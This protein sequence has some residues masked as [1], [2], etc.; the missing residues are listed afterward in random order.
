MMFKKTP[1]EFDA[2]RY[3]AAYPDVALSGL[4]PRQHY[5]QF[6]RQLGRSP[7]GLPRGTA[8]P[9]RPET[10]GQV[11]E[12]APSTSPGCTPVKE[13]LL[14]RS[15]P[16][17]ERP[18]G[19]AASDA[20]S[21]PAPARKGLNGD[22]IFTLDDFSADIPA[23]ALGLERVLAP[24]TDYARLLSFEVPA[25]AGGSE[26]GLRDQS[27]FRKGPTRIENAWF[28]APMT[29]RL[30]VAGVAS[31][32]TTNSGWALR[33]YQAKADSPGQLRAT[34]PG[35]CL[36]AMG[37]GFVDL[38]LVDPLMPLILELADSENVTRAMAIWPFPSL[39]PGGLHA[40]ELRALQT[41]SNPIDGFWDLSE[42]LLREA[43]GELGW[44]A[45]SVRQVNYPLGNDV[46]GHISS[47]LEPWLNA[48]FGVSLESSKKIKSGA[49]SLL[50]LP[51]DCIP[52]ISALV[53]RRLNLRSGDRLSG[54]LLVT[55]GEK[56]R[57]RWSVS[58]P[59]NWP[60][61]ASLPALE[62]I[63][64][65]TKGQSV[66][67]AIPVHLAI[68]NRAP[69]P[70]RLVASMSP[71]TDVAVEPMTIVIDASDEMRTEATVRSLREM[72]GKRDV[73]FIVRFPVDG[74]EFAEVLASV[75]GKSK[76]RGVSHFAD[77]R[78]VARE[79]RH[80]TLLTVNDQ[81]ELEGPGTLAAL[82]Q[83][84]HK[85]DDIGSV[86]CAIFGEKIVR[87][88]SVRQ[89]TFGGIFPAGVSFTSSPR[90]TFVE[91]DV[92][93]ALPATAYPVLANTFNLTV[94]NRDV[95]VR[96]PAIEGPVSPQTADIRLG[97]DLIEL[98]YR[99]VC[100]TIVSAS[101]RGPHV[102]RDAI[103]PVGATYVEP[104]RWAKIMESVTVVRELF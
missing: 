50:R 24:L 87:K 10:M 68:A 100:T 56:N 58:L 40:A 3:R 63:G 69:D 25:G 95:L 46:A 44:P 67:T 61:Q 70:S 88:D 62:G 27:C 31:P 6:G 102:R 64:G 75:C 30:M 83:L 57:P 93:P 26:A 71:A 78:E 59:S 1:V 91:P 85:S 16:I 15:E 51:A 33:A 49:G 2:D 9:E 39:L 20:V 23:G 48:V 90:L 17:I 92:L 43:I 12:D 98:G 104:G 42:I 28:A 37:P 72:V 81:V 101:I 36:P 45:R 18:A 11:R 35:I 60:A 21:V 29:L 5:L 77:L 76:W 38:E 80:K 19:F 55:E 82:L 74:T 34:G 73:E 8:R 94:W 47:I 66:V 7:T 84:L 53:S 32:L 79:A 52:T 13:Q 103:D 97:L 22:G 54:T 86:S 14:V 89:P 99:S 96:L 41:S 65:T 4:T